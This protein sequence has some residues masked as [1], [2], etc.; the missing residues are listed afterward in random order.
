MS[1]FTLSQICD[2]LEEVMARPGFARQ[3]H[4]R[5]ANAVNN[6]VTQTLN[7]KS[8]LGAEATRRYSE[9]LGEQLADIWRDLHS[10]PVRDIKLKKENF[11]QESYIEY[12]INNG[13]S[14]EAVS[15]CPFH[16]I[17]ITKAVL[18]INSLGVKWNVL[19]YNPDYN[20][21]VPVYLCGFDKSQKNTENL[22]NETIF[23]NDST[24]LLYATCKSLNTPRLLLR[25]RNLDK[26]TPT[27]TYNGPY[28]FSVVNLPEL[29]E[30]ENNI[31]ELIKGAAKNGGR[32]G[33]ER[34]KYLHVPFS[35]GT[36]EDLQSIFI[37]GGIKPANIRKSLTKSLKGIYIPSKSEL[38]YIYNLYRL[39][40]EM[41]K[42]RKTPLT[43]FVYLPDLVCPYLAPA[44]FAGTLYFEEH[45]GI[46][47][48]QYARLLYLMQ[49][50]FSMFFQQVVSSVETNIIQV[51]L[52]T[53]IRTE[54]TWAGMYTSIG[55]DKET[56]KLL[57]ED[58]P[59]LSKLKAANEKNILDNTMHNIFKLIDEQF[60]Q[61][62]Q[63]SGK[64]SVDVKG[65]FHEK[66]TLD[67]ALCS[68]A[69]GYHALSKHAFATI[70]HLWDEFGIINKETYDTMS[71]SSNERKT[72]TEKEPE[73]LNS[74]L[75]LVEHLL[76]FEPTLHYIKSYRDHF[77]HS[78]N[79]L[80]LV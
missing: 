31:Q 5:V 27:R 43:H 80:L 74:L 64:Y 26:L 69:F 15:F 63:P 51:V 17:S 39:H 71:R 18:Y 53:G 9:L 30:K 37:R 67:D 73:A 49:H 6:A 46:E 10:I 68:P 21:R 41:R 44:G 16:Y 12:V 57:I 33:K 23:S 76:F 75:F 47:T 34:K 19:Q 40:Y 2:G 42:D 7:T 36:Y 54:L 25:L 8:F 52:D 45:D 32:N 3:M 65:H 62:V 59:L 78:F 20:V 58:V 72:G 50:F 24:H 38:L 22:Y 4:L 35:K 56:K 66:M 79:V 55:K 29:N 13:K 77:M 14:K 61:K 70:K 60:I 28:P 1:E 11:I 48:D